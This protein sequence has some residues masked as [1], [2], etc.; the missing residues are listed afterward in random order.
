[1]DVLREIVRHPVALFFI[2]VA[3]GGG[4]GS[5][6]IAGISL[7][8]SG[9]LFVALA[10][11]H[12]GYSLPSDLQELGII[13]FVYAV[14]LQAG[15][16]FFNQF[17]KR[18]VLFAKIGIFVVAAGALV[19]LALRVGLGLDPALAVGMYA[20]ALT[21]TPGLAAAM[22]A[23]RDPRVSV[24]F[25]LTYPFGVVGVVLLMQLLPRLLQIDVEAE[26]K[27][28]ADSEAATDSLQ[29][30]QF[31]ITNPACVGKTLSDLRLHRFGEANITRISRGGTVVPAKDDTPLAL[32][33]L[34]VVVGKAEELDKVELLLGTRV[35]AQHLLESRDVVARDAI[36][37]SD[38][39]VGKTLAELG[40]RRNYGVV[41]SRVFREDL[42]FAPAGNYTLELGDTIRVVGTRGDV[43]RFVE[44]IGQQE[45][46]IHETNITALAVGIVLGVLLAYH[47]F[48]L[49]GGVSF[50]LGLAGGP[51][52]VSL[53]L[54]HF[55]RIGP[56]NLRTP[57][58]AKYILQQL[59]L[60]LF[61]AGAGTAAGEKLDET[62]VE[63]GWIL[64]G[65]GALVTLTAALVGFVVTR[66]WFRLD[67]F[68]SLGA[69]CGGMTSTPALGAV[70]E[71][72][73]RSEAVV[74]YT[75]VYPVA[76]IF[77]TVL[78]QILWY[79]L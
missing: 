17:R 69:V 45:K 6:R 31:Q 60:V 47:G 46:R 64:L 25:G 65:S 4:L 53:L 72:T 24:G 41:I 51:L 54:A 42:D 77:I 13:L 20:G 48:S 50:R 11:G 71:L 3:L 76:L 22:D 18:G 66:Y 57:R 68:S 36:V 38:K 70:T 34:V 12:F 14:G 33:D 62:L 79:L 23:A 37:S 40:V 75:S 78:C 15:P 7:G 30:R 74:A 9:V 8:T 67:L 28:M 55:G 44:L 59:G 10:F 19:T 21:S 56:L 26:E 16:R 73:N 27:R 1:M 2:I 52:F 5:L 61:L 32:N 58:G 35:E 63:S 39:L 49:P 43:E 29:L